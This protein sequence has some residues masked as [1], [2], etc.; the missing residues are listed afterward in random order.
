LVEPYDFF[1]SY[2]RASGSE[3]VGQLADALEARGKTV[4]LDRLGIEDFDEVTL[5]IQDALLG[6]RCLVPWFAR[7]YLESPAC[8]YELSTF[9]ARAMARGEL[10]ERV[11]VLNPEPTLDH[12][13]PRILR[14]L[15]VASVAEADFGEL[16]RKLSTAADRVTGAVGPMAEAAEAEWYGLPS[17]TGEAA[18]VGRR[19][20]LF[21]ILDALHGQG[22]VI[23]FGTDPAPVAQIIGL[24]GVGKTFLAVVYAR[25]FRSLYPGGVFW[26]RAFGYGLGQGKTERERESA[27]ARQIRGILGQ[28]AVDV[29]NVAAE[30]LDAC[31]QLTL[32]KAGDYLWIVDDLPPEFSAGELTAW[33]APTARGRTLLTS[34]SAHLAAMGTKIELGPLGDRESLQL[35]RRSRDAGGDDESTAAL[36]LVRRLGGFPQALA[37]QAY[38]LKTETYTEAVERL[39]KPARVFEL[40]EHV[41]GLPTGHERDLLHTIGSSLDVVSDEALGVLRLAAVL[42]QIAIPFSLADACLARDAD[43]GRCPDVRGAIQEVA[44]HSLATIQPD[45]SFDVHGLVRAAVAVLRSG[46]SGVELRKSA[47]RALCRALPETVRFKHTRNLALLYQHALGLTKHIDDLDAAILVGR[48]ATYDASLGF[49]E[50]EISGFQRQLDWMSANLGPGHRET[51]QSLFEVASN[52]EEGPRGVEEAL[53]RSREWLGEDD[54]LTMRLEQS[55]AARL[56]IE[57]NERAA[58]DALLPLAE[59]QSAVLGPGHRDTLRTRNSIVF[60]VGRSDPERGLELAERAHLDARASLG[61]DDIDTLNLQ[62][63]RGVLMNECG[64]SHEATSL[65]ARTFERFCDLLGEDH[66]LA[67]RAANNLFIAACEAG[68]YDVALH[69]FRRGLRPALTADAEGRWIAPIQRQI[70]VG[71]RAGMFAAIESNW[72]VAERDRQ[73]GR[74]ADARTLSELNFEICDAIVG[75]DDNYAVAAADLL[76]DLERED[77]RVAIDGLAR[78]L[79]WLA[80]RKRS[81]LP[82]LQRKL[83]R[84]VRKLLRKAAPAA[85]P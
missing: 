61:R 20:E 79:S 60:I 44:D 28:L 69:C 29:S 26:L 6:S 81:E 14:D 40:S 3:H 57:G 21:E 85:T 43:A 35:L 59:R 33:A 76:S 5:A 7:D 15:Q 74:Y 63:V 65:L 25:R 55:H 71:L 67:T 10:G 18:F 16:A 51:I 34:R 27:R 45:E 77:D 32:A 70:V 54:P 23:A 17:L 49:R 58:L 22:R 2:R 73:A 12:I 36:E 42:P 66:Y 53:A 78:R 64:A 48:V 56:D 50:G 80:D 84:K 1:I 30:E 68:D 4:F 39:S 11:L 82:P 38:R 62:M 37:L 19:D 83:R 41:R 46:E 8:W 75:R 72:R 24:G 31:L 47:V 9:V 13:A 52:R